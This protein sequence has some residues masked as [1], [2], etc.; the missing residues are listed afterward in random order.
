MFNLYQAEAQLNTIQEMWSCWCHV[1]AVVTQALCHCQHT[2]K[3]TT[4]NQLHT[5]TT[6]TPLLQIGKLYV[7]N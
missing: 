3:N 7:A 4:N 6:H 5:H 2:L 1:L